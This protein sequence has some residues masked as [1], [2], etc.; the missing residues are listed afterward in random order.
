VLSGWFEAV[1]AAAA[2]SCSRR[3][4]LHGHDHEVV[5][6]PPNEEFNSQVRWPSFFW[7]IFVC[8]GD[9]KSNTVLARLLGIFWILLGTANLACSASIAA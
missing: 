5:K 8:T 1:A 3:K 6:T 2:A 9:T 4:Y 7:L